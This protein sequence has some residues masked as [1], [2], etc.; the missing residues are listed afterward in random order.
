MTQSDANHSPQKKF[1]DKQGKNRDVA[2]FR[3]YFSDPGLEKPVW[4]LGFSEEFPR[5]RNREF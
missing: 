3:G 2:P 1:P 4:L 5:N